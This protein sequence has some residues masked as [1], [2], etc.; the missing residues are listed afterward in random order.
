MRADKVFALPDGLDPR[1]GALVEPMATAWHAVR[2]GDVRTDHT[3]L[4]VGAGPIGVGLWFALRALGVT[5]IVVS[6]PVASR[7]AV[8]AALGAEHV[9]DPVHAIVAVERLSAGQGA[10]V[11]FEAAGSGAAVHAALAALS[12]RGVLVGV[13]LHEREFA[14]N[15][16]PSVFAEHTFVGSIAY[17]P[18]DFREVIDAMTR[19]WYRMDGWVSTVG[20]DEVGHALREL[21]AGR[22][23]KVLVAV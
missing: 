5:R 6:E 22:G 3:V 12:P 2:R 23:M 17:R 18:T 1:L 14:F 21:R 10:D 11:A 15:P 20:F 7:R 9:V 4:V 13:A 16:S 19:G 8:L